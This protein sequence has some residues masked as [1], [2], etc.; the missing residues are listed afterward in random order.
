MK[1][2]ACFLLAVTLGQDA[3]YAQTSD[4]GIRSQL[5]LGLG[6]HETRV[7]DLLFSPLIYDGLGAMGLE[8]SYERQNATSLHHASAAFDQTSVE[9][10]NSLT[11]PFFGSPVTRQASSATFFLL[12][13]G[14]ARRVVNRSRLGLYLGGLLDHQ[15]HVLE[16]RLAEYEDEGYLLSYALSVWLRADYRIDNSHSV[17][18]E[19][20][21][22]LA[23]FLSRPPF[24][25]VDNEGIQTTQN[26]YFYAHKRGTWG[27]FG[28]YTKWYL[29]ARYTRALSTGFDLGVSYELAYVT[30][31]DPQKLAVLRNGLQASLALNL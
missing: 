23:Y 26:G 16:Y 4:P 31:S 29:R 20:S 7:Q 6:V 28:G 9:S 8:L 21:F 27:A 3:L 10:G 13:Y 15:V 11:F 22:P 30:A 14:Y 1:K 18:M 2:L 12:K 25:I 19:T 17:Q 5:S 24:A